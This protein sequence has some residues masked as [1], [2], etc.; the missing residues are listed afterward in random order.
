[1][2]INLDDGFAF[3]WGAFETIA[4]KNKTALFLDEHLDRLENALEFL[5]IAN[6]PSEDGLLTYINTNNLVNHALKV[7]VSED[8]IVLTHRNNPYGPNTAATGFDL[9]FG[10]LMHDANSPFVRHKTLNRGE[11]QLELAAARQKGLQD[12]VLLNNAGEICETS[13]ANIFFVAGDKVIT[14]PETAGLLRGVIR[15]L[16]L[17]NPAFESFQLTEQNVYKQDLTGFSECFL[18]NSLMG[19]RPV[20]SI[21]EASFN[22]DSQNVTA[23]IAQTYRTIVRERFNV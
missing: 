11:Y 9:D 10:L 6:F 16:L 20:A 19:V 3:G 2:K 14:P 17:S 13:T 12:H 8:N 15:D 5:G 7:M 4:I 22:V 23:H 1:M 21:G 18:T